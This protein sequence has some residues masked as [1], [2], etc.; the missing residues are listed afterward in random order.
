[1]SAK[2]SYRVLIIDDNQEFIDRLMA[3]IVKVDPSLELIME[4]VTSGE[5]G[6]DRVGEFLPD[7]ILLDNMLAEEDS[8]FDFISA[9]DVYAALRKKGFHGIKVIVITYDPQVHQANDLVKSGVKAV[10]NK[11]DLFYDPEGY[12]RLVDLIRD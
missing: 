2:T 7:V 12:R 5:K 3:R 6:I 1:M 10:F 8:S 9:R 11:D 4:G